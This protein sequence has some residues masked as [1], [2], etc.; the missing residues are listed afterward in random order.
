MKML[1]AQAAGLALHLDARR[2]ALAAPPL[3]KA[4]FC[5]DF[6]GIFFVA[7]EPIPVFRFLRRRKIAPHPDAWV[8]WNLKETVESVSLHCCTS[9][10]VDSLDMGSGE[11]YADSS[12]RWCIG[13]KTAERTVVWEQ[14]PRIERKAGNAGWAVFVDYVRVKGLALPSPPSVKDAEAALGLALENAAGFAARHFFP[15]YSTLFLAAK[16]YLLTGEVDPFLGD[17]Q[18]SHIAPQFP[19]IAPPHSLQRSAERVLNASFFAWPFG[20]MGSWNDYN[21]EEKGLNLLHEERS[22]KLYRALLDGICSAVCGD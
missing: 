1:A 12:V 4:P 7:D 11:A 19:A 21:H 20:G 17:G 2:R 6:S 22:R 10:A 18:F 16:R 8:E 14:I 3:A 5:R 15:V 9:G 13:V